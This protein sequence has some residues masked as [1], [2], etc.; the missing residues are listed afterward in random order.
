M[1]LSSGLQH[2]AIFLP[3]ARAMEKRKAFRAA[4]V[5]T[6][7]RYLKRY[8]CVVGK[9]VSPQWPRGAEKQRGR[10]LGCG[11]RIMCL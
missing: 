6:G 1:F 8:A 2:F 4:T 10:T 5:A 9:C 3:G 7:R 11:L